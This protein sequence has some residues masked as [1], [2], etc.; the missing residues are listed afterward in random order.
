MSL[1]KV[2]FWLHLAAGVVAGIVI[3]IMSATGVAL[4][5]EKEIV[6]WAERGQRIVAA[7]SSDAKAKTLDELLAAVREANPERRPSAITV[8]ADRTQAV[9]FGFGRTNTVYGNPY[10]GALAE[11]GAAGLR[12]FMRVMIEW[13]RVLGRTEG[14]R[15]TGK[16]ITGA[17]NVAFLVLTATGLY[18]WWPRKWTAATLRAISVP[19]LR[20]RGKARDW[21]WH[22]ALGLW[23]APVLIVLT[24]TALPISYKWAGDLIYKM[25]GTPVPAS[26]GPGGG[27]AAVEV[28]TPAPGSKRLGWQALLAAT[29]AE[30]PG[31]KQVTFRLEGPGG[32]GPRTE[33]G[34]GTN[35]PVEMK[36]GG[37][38]A[39]PAKAENGV[40]KELPPAADSQPGEGRGRREGGGEGRRTPQAVTAVVKLRDAWPKFSTVQLSLDPFTGKVLKR[41]TYDDFNPGRKV[42]S[43]T[44]FLHTGEA[45]GWGGQALAGAGS[46]S[47][48]VLVWTGLAL[49]ARR[50][51]SWTR[52]VKPEPSVAGVEMGAAPQEEPR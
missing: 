52:R 24:A 10:T 5:F 45:L 8:E 19:A 22:N 33:T 42:R 1:R 50:L 11:G 38:P 16:A 15:N 40:R 14:S 17:C 7:P 20:L 32:R 2:I 3:L 46:L 29:Q 13:H 47:G 9:A 21:N 39:Q 49:A 41:E 37:A 6:A 48:V 28:P 43:W 44:R 30:A 34:R 35:S 27:G 4:A 36:D 12:D 18:L 26:G 25:T 31:W 23:S 51:L